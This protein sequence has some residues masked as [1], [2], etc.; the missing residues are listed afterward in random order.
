M[1][2]TR[3]AFWGRAYKQELLSRIVAGMWAWRVTCVSPKEFLVCKRLTGVRKSGDGEV[4]AGN[5]DVIN[6]C[7]DGES[8]SGVSWQTNDANS[9]RP[10]HL[11]PP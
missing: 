6:L 11:A 10:A 2:K 1:A 9:A 8:E 3:K 7:V 5:D 4:D